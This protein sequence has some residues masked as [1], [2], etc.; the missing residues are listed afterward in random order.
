MVI[1]PEIGRVCFLELNNDVRV[2]YLLITRRL[3]PRLVKRSLPPQTSEV[4]GSQALPGKRCPEAL[5]RFQGRQNGG[6]ASRYAFPGS[7]WERVEI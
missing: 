3:K 7:A 2:I 6:R 1:L 5:P 4:T